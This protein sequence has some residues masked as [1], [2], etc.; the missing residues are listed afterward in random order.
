MTGTFSYTPATYT[1]ACCEDQVSTTSDLF[2]CVNDQGNTISVCVQMDTKVYFF[3]LF[4]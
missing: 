3:Y 1:E 4:F 2:K